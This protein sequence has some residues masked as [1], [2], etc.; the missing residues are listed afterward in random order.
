MH[1]FTLLLILGTLGP[2]GWAGCREQVAP[3]IGKPVVT[4]VGGK[5]ALYEKQLSSR[6]NEIKG[7]MFAVSLDSLSDTGRMAGMELPR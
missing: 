7:Y 3:S 5:Y 4:R 6:D 2:A 1:R